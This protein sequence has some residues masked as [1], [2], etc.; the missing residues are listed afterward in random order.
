[1][2]ESITFTAPSI[3]ASALINGDLSLFDYYDD[4]E[5]YEAYKACIKELIEL[6]GNAH[7]VDCKESGFQNYSGDY[8][9]LAGDYS[10]YTILV[11]KGE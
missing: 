11:E 5:G 7:V 10:E 2:L 9:R 6:Y 1:M 3:W 8:G 4:K